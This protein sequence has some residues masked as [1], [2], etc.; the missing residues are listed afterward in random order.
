M[1]NIY[2]I[3]QRLQTVCYLNLLNNMEPQK[4]PPK[5]SY[6]QEVEAVCINPECSNP[7][8]ICSKGMSTGKCCNMFHEYCQKMEWSEI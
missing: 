1:T 5:C 3:H 8:F 6:G 4:N 2:L 7:A